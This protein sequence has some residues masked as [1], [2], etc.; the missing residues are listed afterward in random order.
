MG[1]AER[2]GN[3]F[4]TIYE[5]GVFEIC[6]EHLVGKRGWFA[7]SWCRKGLGAHGTRTNPTL[8]SPFVG[9]CRSVVA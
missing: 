7:R 3:R 4:S 6:I 9:L 5:V 8:S 1:I 2:S